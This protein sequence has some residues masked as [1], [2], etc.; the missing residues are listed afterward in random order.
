M[1]CFGCGSSEGMAMG[2]S[3]Q[4]RAEWRRATKGPLNNLQQ[5]FLRQ[6]KTIAMAVKP[7]LSAQQIVA[8]DKLVQCAQ[9]PGC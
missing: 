6:S 4:D 7:T 3:G 2:T 8:I 9:L 1:A 5:I